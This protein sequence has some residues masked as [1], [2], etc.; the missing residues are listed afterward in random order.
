ML[1]LFNNKLMKLPIEI[2]ALSNLEEVKSETEQL[3]DKI[4]NHV[5]H[6]EFMV[7]N[8][9][10]IFLCVLLANSKEDSVLSKVIHSVA[11]F[12]SSF[13]VFFSIHNT[14]MKSLC[15]HLSTTI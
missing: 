7:S 14:F 3:R 9:M 4:R 10:G 6:F 5:K 12:I 15:R 11:V 8:Q 2:G 1:N 13:N